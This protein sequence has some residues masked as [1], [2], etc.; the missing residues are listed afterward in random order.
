M[1]LVFFLHQ[2]HMGHLFQAHLPFNLVTSTALQF[3]PQPL[4]ETLY[5]FHCTSAAFIPLCMT[6]VQSSARP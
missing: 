3:L 5:I 2:Q 4:R 6:S 1:L